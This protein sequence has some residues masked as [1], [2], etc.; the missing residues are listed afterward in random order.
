MHA[1][2]CGL[3]ASNGKQEQQPNINPRIP[4]DPGMTGSK[5]STLADL[6]NSW[7]SQHHRHNLKD[8]LETH[9]TRLDWQYIQ[10]IQ[11]Q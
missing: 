3:Q 5:S 2:C 10:Y 1:T 9:L 8:C 7:T 4:A 6:R 11:Y